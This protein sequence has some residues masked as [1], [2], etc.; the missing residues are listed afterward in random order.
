MIDNDEGK[1]KLYLFGFSADDLNYSDLVDDDEDD[2]DW[3]DPD[4]HD[5]D[6]MY[7]HEDE[8]NRGEY[9]N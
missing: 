2:E 7:D 1:K 3:N 9:D 8:E 5:E 4:L 6:W